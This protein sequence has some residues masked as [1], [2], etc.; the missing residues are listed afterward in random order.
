MAL[1]TTE[2]KEWI[3]DKLQSLAP[4]GNA[5]M[6][7]GLSGTGITA[8][9]VSNTIATFTEVSEARVAGTL[10]QPTSTT[11]RL[12]WTTAYTGTKT[13]TE[14]GRTNTT[15]KGDANE[16]LLGRAKFGTGIGVENGD[17]IGFTFDNLA[18]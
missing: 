18:T 17:S 8:E 2:G 9:N 14:I 1:I 16:K 11:D 10:S 5:T 13:V 3:T 7:V 6:S 15:T 12:V 4:L